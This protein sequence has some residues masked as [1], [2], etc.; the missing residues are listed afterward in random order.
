MNC[1]V[2]L[3]AFSLSQISIEAAKKYTTDFT[4][5]TAEFI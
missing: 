4:A 5:I 2:C 3:F 1:F